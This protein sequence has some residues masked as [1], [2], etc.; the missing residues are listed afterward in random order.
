MSELLLTRR[1]GQ[2]TEG[3]V[4]SLGGEVTNDVGSVTTPKRNETLLSVG[5]G[6]SVANTLVGGSKTA[7][8]DLKTERVSKARTTRRK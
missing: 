6:E 8:L 2:L 4:K 3:K 5:A 1:N 7:L